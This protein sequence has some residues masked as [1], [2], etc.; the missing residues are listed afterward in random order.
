MSTVDPLESFI[1]IRPRSEEEK[2]KRHL[3][4]DI[5]GTMPRSRTRQNV[6]QQLYGE[7]SNIFEGLLQ[8]LSVIPHS[9]GKLKSSII[10]RC[11]THTR[12][13]IIEPPVNCV[14]FH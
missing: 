9:L 14:T 4:S 3:N 6:Q 13:M 2:K 11:N 8:K 1:A 10:L 12:E 7:A 5:G